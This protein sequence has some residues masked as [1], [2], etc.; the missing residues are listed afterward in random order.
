MLDSY[1]R[2]VS[3]EA[4]NFARR[5]CGKRVLGQYYWG[6]YTWLSWSVEG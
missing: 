3:D 6:P 5:S 1:S 2:S 4:I